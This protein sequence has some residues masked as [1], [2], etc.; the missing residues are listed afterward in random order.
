V[1][2]VQ[3]ELLTW[4]QMPLEVYFGEISGKKGDVEAVL[5]F[6]NEVLWR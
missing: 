4:Q 3:G 1:L 2:G 5:T 6:A